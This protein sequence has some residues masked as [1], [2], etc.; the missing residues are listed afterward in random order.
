MESYPSSDNVRESWKTIPLRIPSGF[1]CDKCEVPTLLV[2]SQAGGL[3]TH[4]CPQ[5]KGFNTITKE[6]FKD[7][8]DV[9]LSCPKC[10]ERM[11]PD[12]LSYGNYGY[13]CIPCDLSI[14]LAD[15]LPWRE[16]F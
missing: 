1:F 12:I 8:L 13:V 5:C 4:N 14:K 10:R 3:V 11:A 15:V 9:Y 6:V 7:E 16:D 2:Q